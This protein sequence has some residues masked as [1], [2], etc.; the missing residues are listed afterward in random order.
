MICLVVIGIGRVDAIEKTCSI[1]P[2][3]APDKS[4]DDVPV[5]LSL[6][7]RKQSCCRV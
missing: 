2:A 6:R 7:L 1:H 4:D 5:P 3:E